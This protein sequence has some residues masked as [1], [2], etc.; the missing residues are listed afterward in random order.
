MRREINSLTDLAQGPPAMSSVPIFSTAGWRNDLPETLNVRA[1]GAAGDSV[2]DDT[3]AI[4][5]AINA[6]S[7]RGSG[8]VFMPPG[9]YKV[10]ALQAKAGGVIRGAGGSP[11]A[12]NQTNLQG[13]AGSNVLELP[14]TSSQ[15]GFGF[16]DLVISGG[17]HGLY[18]PDN[19]G[20][21][22]TYLRM[23]NVH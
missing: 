2:T 22:H 9:S 4:D 5:D 7:A 16:E 10:R 11:N 13:M 17:V 19:G 1:F 14:T 8:E 6:C 12:A 15:V 20:S 23:R 3:V 18:A 21:Y